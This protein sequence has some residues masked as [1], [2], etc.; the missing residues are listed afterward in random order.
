ML[1][2]QRKN[3]DLPEEIRNLI[4]FRFL[5]DLEQEQIYTAVSS[6]EEFELNVK[7]S[8]TSPSGERLAR[9]FLFEVSR[10]GFIDGFRDA[11]DNYIPRGRLPSDWSRIEITCWIRPIHPPPTQAT[12][13]EDEFPR[14]LL[15]VA[16]RATQ[17]TRR[18]LPF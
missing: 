15:E 2:S 8:W 9:D 10:L 7:V 3:V 18:A 14:M 16:K 1:G 5:Y 12:P 11:D 13:P 4:A 17:F 6:K